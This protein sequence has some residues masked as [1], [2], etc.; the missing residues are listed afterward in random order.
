MLNI[1]LSGA[2]RQNPDF[3]Q[4][5]RK[6]NEDNIAWL[7]RHCQQ[8][9]GTVLALFGGVDQT[10]FRL[11]VAQSYARHN[12]TPSHW[13]DVVFVDDPAAL[14]PRARTYEASL[15]P[16]GGFDF[17]PNTNSIQAGALGAY[18]DPKEF[19]NVAVLVV[20]VARDAVR[21]AIDQFRSMRNVI[22]GA[23]ILVAWLAHLWGVSAAGNPL[24]QGIG[25]PSAVIMEYAMAAADFDLTPGL[26]SRS[27]CPEA[28]W[29]AA[30]WWH[31]FYITKGEEGG[32]RAIPTRAA[33][34]QA[35]DQPITGAW[36]LDHEISPD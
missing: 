18:A 17:P 23:E 13:S 15:R 27:S 16:A 21:S 3:R 6:R 9:N 30:K 28:I 7:Q 29:Q 20:P 4:S 2:D 35:P 12:L 5:K 32:A 1:V 14:G 33:Q 19:P 22:N 8:P 11:R 36:C 31:R 26:A 24:L 34:P 25:V 10:S